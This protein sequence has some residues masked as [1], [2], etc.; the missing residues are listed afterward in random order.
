M[1][2]TLPSHT[3]AFISAYLAFFCARL[4]RTPFD[5]DPARFVADLA[6]RTRHILSRALIDAFSRVTNL[7]RGQTRIERRA[8]RLDAKQRLNVARLALTTSS[9]LTRLDTATVRGVAKFPAPAVVVDR[10]LVNARVTR[11]RTDRQI[12][13][14]TLVTARVEL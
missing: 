6:F 13:N 11:R 9:G 2:R 8:L 14:L 12:T 1:H 5:A 7:I 3:D 10:T 4:D